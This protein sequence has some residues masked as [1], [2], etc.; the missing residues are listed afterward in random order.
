MSPRPILVPLAAVLAFAVFPAAAPAK[1]RRHADLTVM[2]QNL[3]LGA[4]VITLATAQNQSDEAQHASQLVAT[5]NQ[6]N[7]PLRAQAIAREI[8]AAKPD[9]I[10]LQEVSE[11][12]RGP[13]GVNDH[14]KDATT[15]VADWMTILQGELRKRGQH[16]KVAARQN[17]DDVETAL[18]EGYDFRATW[19]EAVLVRTGKGAR[20]SHV[21]GFSGTFKHQLDVPLAD[22]VIHQTRGYAGIDA[23]VAGKH[24]RLLDPHAEAYSDAI[25]TAEFKELLAGPAASKHRTTI[26]AGDYNS[27]PN[28]GGGYDAVIKAGYVDTGKKASTCCQDETVDNPASKLTQWIDHIVARPRVK[29]LSSRLVGNL[30]SDR[31]GGLWPSDHAGVVAK[32]RLR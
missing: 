1:A 16:Y 7:F 19:G 17:Y 4:D 27:A 8:A 10:S 5:L 25:A 23:V 21:K 13:D 11:Y 2:T 15:P 18:A 30:A 9:V 28:R 6:T 29:V 22:Q 24:F 26:I 20:V 12:H 31:I 32:L 3:Y 14:V